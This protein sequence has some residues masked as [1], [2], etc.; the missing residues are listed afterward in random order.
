MLKLVVY[1]AIYPFDPKKIYN[2]EIVLTSNNK[3]YQYKKNSL[4]LIDT[5]KRWL[6]FNLIENDQKL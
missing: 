4:H 2:S 6:I 1:K 5:M 3:R